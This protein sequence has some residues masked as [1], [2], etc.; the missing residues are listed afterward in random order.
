[1][2]WHAPWKRSGWAL[3]LVL[4][5]SME[6][7]PWGLRALSGSSQPE[8]PG[9]WEMREVPGRWEVVNLNSVKLPRAWAAHPAMCMAGGTDELPGALVDSLSLLGQSD[10]PLAELEASGTNVWGAH[11]VRRT[12]GAPCHTRGCVSPSRSSPTR[13]LFQ[14]GHRRRTGPPGSQAWWSKTGRCIPGA[15]LS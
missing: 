9:T 8:V 12:G 1:M 13:R 14:A 11:T 3:G 4:K 6:T 15:F 7:E 10:A 2:R 5:A